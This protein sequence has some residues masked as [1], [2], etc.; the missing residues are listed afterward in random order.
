MEE[1]RD[2]ASRS[3]PEFRENVAKLEKEVRRY[4][5]R[6]ET[7]GDELEAKRVRSKHETDSDLQE[8]HA[9]MLS[10]REGAERE[11]AHYKKSED[12]YAAQLANSATELTRVK[13]AVAV[14]AFCRKI[15]KQLTSQ[16]WTEQAEKIA[17]RIETTDSPKRI[18]EKRASIAETIEA[19]KKRQVHR[20][21]TQAI[22]MGLFL[23]RRG[24]VVN[25][26]LHPAH[27][28]AEKGY[29]EDRKKVEQLEIFCK[30]R[31]PSSALES[32]AEQ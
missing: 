21:P 29:N 2:A 22:D 24:A 32:R 9:Q 27:A 15:R 20:D 28:A 8:K 5:Q 30:V 23:T 19:A 7:F 11:I 4:D 13:D 18:T 14:S 25:D 10:N 1:E 12:R 6:L 3:L 16:N 17:P 26:D 31:C